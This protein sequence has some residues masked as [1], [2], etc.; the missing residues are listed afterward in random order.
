M[1]RRSLKLGLLAVLLTAVTGAVVIK[2]RSAHAG[3]GHH[4]RAAIM[5]RI[6]NAHIDEVLDD[7]K[8][9][10]AQRNTVYAARDRVFNAVESHMRDRKSHTEEVLQLFE[11]DRVEQDKITALRS[12]RT[13]EMQQLGDVITQA[14]VEVHDVLTPQQRRVVTDHVRSFRNSHGQ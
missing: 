5:K 9:N 14:L 3:W 11:A 8:V 1:T 10:Q 13:A 4:P 12:R 7:A 2:H 6:V